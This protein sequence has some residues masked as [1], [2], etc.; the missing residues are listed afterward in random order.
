[1]TPD[2]ENIEN[3]DIVSSDTEQTDKP[4]AYTEEFHLDG[5]QDNIRKLYEKL[6][7]EM[8]T[9]IHNLTFNP[10]R[11]YISLRKKRNFAFLKIRRKKIAI[12]AMATE[13]KI[14]AT[15]PNYNVET[16]SEPVQ[17]FYNGDCAR[18]DVTNDKHL[19][20]ILDLLTDIQK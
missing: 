3:I 18:I 13:K 7:A 11:Y 10:Q 4:T 15:V 19:D 17:R 6:K 9:R 16:L 5:V 20:E 2:F 14:R 8:S 1:M 12:V